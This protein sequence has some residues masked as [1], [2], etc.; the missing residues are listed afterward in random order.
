MQKISLFHLFL[1]FIT[2]AFPS[3]IKTAK[4]VPVF[5]KD[6][7]LVYSNYRPISLSSNVEKILEKLMFKRLYT[8][9]TTMFYILCL[10]Q[11][12]LKNM[13]VC[14]YQ[15]LFFEHNWPVRKKDFYNFEIEKIGLILIYLRRFSSSSL[16]STSCVYFFCNVH[17]TTSMEPCSQGSL[18]F[19]PVYGV[20]VGGNPKTLKY[21]VGVQQGQFFLSG[22][23]KVPLQ[24]WLATLLL[25]ASQ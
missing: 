12:R 7:K 2:V 25:M 19:C 16:C 11:A 6:S 3:V 9:L 8:F 22:R 21:W 5:K 13:L 24:P 15:G 1:S 14:H 17:A 23:K 10:N 20:I 4:I 18:S